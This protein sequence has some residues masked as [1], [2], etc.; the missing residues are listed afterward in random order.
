MTSLRSGAKMGLMKNTIKKFLNGEYSLVVSFWI[1][2]TVP[3]V[4]IAIFSIIVAIIFAIN[5]IVLFSIVDNN[6]L[7]Y[8][9]TECKK[10]NIPGFEVLGNLISDFSKL[11]EQK[12]SRKPSGQHILDEE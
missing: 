11:L 10:N 5:V 3:G 6:L 7:K 4:I 8:L 12:A 1:F 9:A 2:G